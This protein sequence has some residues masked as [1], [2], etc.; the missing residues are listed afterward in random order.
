M[1]LLGFT[2][3]LNSKQHLNWIVYMV[4]FMAIRPCGYRLDFEKAH[5]FKWW[6]LYK[7]FGKKVA[8]LLIINILIRKTNENHVML[9]CSWCLQ[10]WR[11]STCSTRWR[12]TLTAVSPSPSPPRGW[13]SPTPSSWEPPLTCRLCHCPR[14]PPRS[15]CTLPE[16]AVPPYR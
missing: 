4:V 13:S 1:I 3:R 9:C 8:G 10:P 5:S 6:I 2:K 11:R 7:R 12:R 15:S 14:C 16:L